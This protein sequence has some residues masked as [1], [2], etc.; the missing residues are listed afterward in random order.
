MSQNKDSPWC[1]NMEQK[2]RLKHS[3]NPPSVCLHWARCQFPTLWRQYGISKSHKCSV[4]MFILM[5]Q[6]PCCVQVWMMWW[7]GMSSS[8]ILYSEVKQTFSVNLWSEKS[9]W[10]LCFQDN[11]NIF[12]RKKKKMKSS[13]CRAFWGLANRWDCYKGFI[14]ITLTNIKSVWCSLPEC[15]RTNRNSAEILQ[16]ECKC[17]WHNCAGC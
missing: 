5:T 8:V 11:E 4:C 14:P 10:D 15:H 6:M 16:A 9:V 1:A 2:E 12:S 17:L 3:N 13:W 7:F